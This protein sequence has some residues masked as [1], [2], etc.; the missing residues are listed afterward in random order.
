MTPTWPRARAVAGDR[1]VIKATAGDFRVSELPSITPAGAGEHLWLHL[2]KTGRSTVEV[3]RW[4][5]DAFGVPEHGVG[6][7]GM[8]DKHAVTAQWFSVHTPAAAAVLPAAA[9]VR[10][11]DAARHRRK[12]RRGELAGNRFELRLREVVGDAWR[13]GLGRLRDGGA[14]NYFG[15][16]RFGSDNLANARAWLGGEGA[17]GRRRRLPA[18]RRGL[19]LSVL[20]SFLFN[21]V[22]AA[23]VRSGTWQQLLAGDVPACG[24]AAAVPTGPLWGRGRSPAAAEAARMEAAA[25]E[26]YGDV[27]EGLEHAGL[28]QERRPLVL[29]AADLDW[30]H[31]GDVLTLSFTLPPGTYATALLGEA[32]TLVAAERAGP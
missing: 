16:Q 30:T 5:A 6:Y 1:A 11:L 7:A 19:Y 18:F 24:D 10:L 26:P 27:R 25:L 20:R 9:D 14:P 31:S 21:E 12:L 3:A 32:F 23:R 2:E 22:L 28:V 8:K 13:D 29:P 4:L 17:G 15:P